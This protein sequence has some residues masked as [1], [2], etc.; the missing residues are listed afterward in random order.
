MAFHY[1]HAF[2][3]FLVLLSIIAVGPSTQNSVANVHLRVEGLNTTIFSGD[4]ATRGHDVTVN[5]FNIM[6]RCDGTNANRNPTRG[7]TVTSALDDAA[8]YRGLPWHGTWYD[9]TGNITLEDFDITSINRDTTTPNVTHLTLLI[10]YVPLSMGGC[11]QRVST[12]NNVLLAFHAHDNNIFLKLEVDRKTV[13]V[14]QPVVVTVTN[15]W[16]ARPISGARVGTATTGNDGKATLT[17]TTAGPQTLMATKHPTV[18]SDKIAIMV[19]NPTNATSV[20]EVSY[21][22]S[23]ALP[24]EFADINRRC[25]AIGKIGGLLLDVQKPM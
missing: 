23:V 5:P 15:G 10:D 22:S 17:Y 1:Q 24:N 16:N 6:R 20:S 8:R 2:I 14:I 19:L 21:P 3:T 9:Q 25:Q 4:V 11:Q 13:M 18:R 7:A 12:G